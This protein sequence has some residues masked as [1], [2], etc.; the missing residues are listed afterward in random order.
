MTYYSAKAATP[1]LVRERPT[2]YIL[3]AGHEELAAKLQRQGVKGF[4]LTKET[5]LSV[6]AYSVSSRIENEAYENKPNVD[7]Q[8]IVKKKTVMFPKEATSFNIS[9]AKQ[10]IVSIA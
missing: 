5:A 10:F 1:T 9:A 3:K 4:K 6:E 7:V 8:T 2:A